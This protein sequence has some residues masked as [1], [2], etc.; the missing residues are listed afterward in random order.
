M[1]FLAEYEEMKDVPRHIAITYKF[2]SIFKVKDLGIH[3]GPSHMHTTTVT[4]ADAFKAFLK[5]QKT[6]LKEGALTK[7]ECSRRMW[8]FYQKILE[9]GLFSLEVRQEILKWM[10]VCELVIS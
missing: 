3:W 1:D 5:A 10:E 8:F 6:D 7:S 9:H 4:I 2:F